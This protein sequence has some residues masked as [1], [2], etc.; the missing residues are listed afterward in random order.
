MV[1]EIGSPRRIK[2]VLHIEDILRK[3]DI[4]PYRLVWYGSDEL[5]A[6]SLEKA[7]ADARAR[8]QPTE[9]FDR[10]Y[11]RS[12][13]KLI[14]RITEDYEGQV[15]DVTLQYLKSMNNLKS[16]IFDEEYIVKFIEQV[17]ISDDDKVTMIVNEK[18][19]SYLANKIE[20]CSIYNDDSVKTMCIIQNFRKFFDDWETFK[21]DWKRMS[22]IVRDVV[23]DE[24]YEFLIQ[25]GGIYDE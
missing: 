2:I 8:V 9:E 4:T 14:E 10:A 7:E 18:G 21:I 15:R 24:G 17:Y 11:R 3:A 6:N 22:G 23:K 20:D 12:K 13:P 25:Q 19:L 5:I 1:T 16:K